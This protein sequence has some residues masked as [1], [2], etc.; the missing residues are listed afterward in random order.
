MRRLHA[1]KGMALAML[2]ALL[3]AAG[4]CAKTPV[5]PVSRRLPGRLWTRRA[6]SDGGISPARR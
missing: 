6:A 2:P 4:G 3:L 5:A 1:R